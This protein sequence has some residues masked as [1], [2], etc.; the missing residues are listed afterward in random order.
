MAEFFFDT[1]RRQN[2]DSGKF[3]YTP[4]SELR[5][6]QSKKLRI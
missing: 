4:C 1:L 5:Y 3:N 2:A 6:K